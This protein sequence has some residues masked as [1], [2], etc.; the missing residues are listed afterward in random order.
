MNTTDILICVALGIIGT[1]ILGVIVFILMF[2]AASLS[3]H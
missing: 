1:P 2:V 3:K